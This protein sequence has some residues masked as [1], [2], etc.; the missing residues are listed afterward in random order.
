MQGA[1][2]LQLIILCNLGGKIWT[3]DLSLWLRDLPQNVTAWH[4]A[5]RSKIT[6]KE[7]CS[8]ADQGREKG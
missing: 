8:A 1:G 7:R 5:V 3:G 6:D 2:P 4:R